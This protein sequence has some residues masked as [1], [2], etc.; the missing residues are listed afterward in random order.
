MSCISITQ[1]VGKT[2]WEKNMAFNRC[3]VCQSAQ[4]LQ[5]F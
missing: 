4:C 3:P 5:N 2:K 1:H